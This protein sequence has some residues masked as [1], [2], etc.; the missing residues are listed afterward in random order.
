MRSTIIARIGRTFEITGRP[1]V[2]TY[3]ATYSYTFGTVGGGS[4][5]TWTH[6]SL[7]S[8]GA[9]FDDSTGILSSAFLTSGGSFPFTL[10]AT[11]EARNF[12]SANFVLIVTGSPA[13]RLVTEAGDPIVTESGLQMIPQ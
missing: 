1:P 4:V 12:A 11:D 13:F 2:G 9:T 6:T 8:S 10:T 5:I 7:G 3:G